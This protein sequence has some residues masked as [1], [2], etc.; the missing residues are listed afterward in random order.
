[1]RLELEEY[2][3]LASPCPIDWSTVV[4]SNREWIE[5]LV[6]ARTGSQD[7]VDDVIQEVSLAI[8]RSSS[9]PAGSEDV[10]PWLCKIVVRQCALIVRQRVRH[11]RK[12][13]A[14]HRTLELDETQSA[15]P[16]FWLLHEEQ[17]AIIHEELRAMDPQS[18]QL[19][20]WKYLNSLAY[21]EIGSRLGV[22]RHVAEY[23]VIEAKKQLR[24]RLQARGINQGELP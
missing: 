1:M 16:I 10:G 15:D 9:R 13:E 12:L 21:E 22:S 24:T 14:Y 8:T 2:P 20:I 17:R 3:M 23:R 11:Q 18:R 4:D 19:L 6:A 5:R 7:F